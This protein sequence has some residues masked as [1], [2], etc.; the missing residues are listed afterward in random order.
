MNYRY[1]LGQDGHALQRNV[2]TL[3]LAVK[4]ADGCEPRHVRCDR[5]RKRSFSGLSPPGPWKQNAPALVV[6][7]T[8]H[9][10][11]NSIQKD[12]K[13][14]P[15]S[16]PYSVYTKVGTFLLHK[17]VQRITPVHSCT[18]G[19]PR[20]TNSSCGLSAEALVHFL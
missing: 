10:D 12:K 3:L 9:T 20:R 8:P 2:D 15:L 1:C 16:P 13:G 18:P 11:T 4:Q 7:T 17:L 6:V 14:A 19:F 5:K